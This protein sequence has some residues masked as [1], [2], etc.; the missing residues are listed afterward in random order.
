[1]NANTAYRNRSIGYGLTNDNRPD[2]GSLPAAGL[3]PVAAVAVPLSGSGRQVNTLLHSVTLPNSLNPIELPLLD[4]V[5]ISK[6]VAWSPS[7][8]VT[9]SAA[10]SRNPALGKG[11]EIMQPPPK[12]SRWKMQQQAAQLL[13]KERVAG[14]LR[15]RVKLSGEEQ[16]V[17]HID[18]LTGALS[19]GYAGLQTCGSVWVCPICSARISDYRREELKAAVTSA[20]AKG[21]HVYL[22]TQTVRHDASIPLEVLADGIQQ[23]RRLLRNRK[24]WKHFAQR[25]GLAGSV[26]ALE[27][28]VGPSG[29][30]VHYHE[31]LFTD[32]TIDQADTLAINA[33]WL[34]ACVSA[35]LPAPNHHGTDIRS[36][37]KADEY[38]SKWGLAD[39]LFTDA[40][41]AK[42]RNRNPW[43]LLT[44]AG[45]G[46][47]HAGK[48]FQE[49]AAVFKGRRQLVWSDG[50]R[51]LLGLGEL[52]TD[53]QLLQTEEVVN[54]LAAIPHQVWK[55]ICEHEQRGE[56]L[57]IFKE[58]AQ[59]GRAWLQEVA[60]ERG[61]QSP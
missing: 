31:L 21:F 17:E 41:G 24:T 43:K 30:H 1:M 36:G 10:T 25:V 20:R 44:D 60:K 32:R 8:Q 33:A 57:A 3:G 50:L 2:A 4:N 53:E 47:D 19:V 22:F 6:E 11:C 38:V 61:G 15:R 16:V 35:G 56:C 39:E 37:D 52:L 48:L 55:V 42:V 58:S 54:V 49:Y 26:R 40:K 23:A 34:K 28:T 14:C 9:T 46:D 18:T 7:G 5:T 51:D 27:V 59:Q 12:V 29:W 13:P 45:N